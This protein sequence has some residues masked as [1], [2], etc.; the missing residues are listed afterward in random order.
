MDDLLA[1]LFPWI[2]KTALPWCVNV[3]ASYPGYAALFGVLY[4][5]GQLMAAAG[6]KRYP[7]YQDRPEFWKWLVIVSDI[8]TLSP[9]T[10]F[11]YFKSDPNPPLSTRPNV[12]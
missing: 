3:V 7:E 1:A 2:V 11:K 9:S 10:L 4:L 12:P 5:L 8:L 6:R